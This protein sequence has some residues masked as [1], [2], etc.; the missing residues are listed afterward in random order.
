MK[1]EIMIGILLE[2][3]SKK[4]VKASYLADKYEVSIRSIYRYINALDYAGI[5]LYSIRG[6][7]G[8]FAIVDTYKIPSTFMTEKEFEKTISALTAIT[9]SV[10]DK[11]LTSAITKLKA[12]IKNEKSGLDLKSGNLII[13]ASPWGD[14]VGYKSK[15]IILQ[16]SIDQNKKLFIRYHDRNGE[17]TERTI[18]PHFIV[19]K[20]GLWYVY[21]YCELRKEF[22]FFKTGRIEYANVTNSDFIR[23]VP[24]QVPL[25]FWDN[26]QETTDV[27]LEI[28]KSHLSD[29]E[30]WLGIENVKQIKDKY[31]ANVK[32]PIDNGLV[33][34][35][36]SYGDGVKVLEPEQLKNQ[37]KL[38]AQSIL[39]NY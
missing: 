36:M 33:S 5:P 4:F 15:L 34:K 32:L 8:G 19:F 27:S 26:L 2:L 12:V 23:Q 29:V 11:V 31:I 35:L 37:I 18:H 16:Q 28:N 17:I 21:A 25:N 10:P 13:D 22:R 7:N 6:N 24:D 14:T 20:Q 9:E 38:T 3:L 1:F 39:K 30:E